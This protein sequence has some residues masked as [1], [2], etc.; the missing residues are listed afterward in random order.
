MSFKYSSVKVSKTHRFNFNLKHST[1]KVEASCLSEKGH[2]EIV[3]VLCLRQIAG[4]NKD[5]VNKPHLLNRL[6][7]PKFLIYLLPNCNE[8]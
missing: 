3:N 4:A 6:I 8:N 5:G 2:I 7:L 1:L